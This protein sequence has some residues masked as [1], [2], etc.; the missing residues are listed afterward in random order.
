MK[1]LLTSIAT[2]SILR[3]KIMDMSKKN[4]LT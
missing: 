2:P 4:G 1:I 3:K